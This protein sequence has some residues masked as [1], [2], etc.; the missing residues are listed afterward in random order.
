MP[1]RRR[2]ASS[3]ARAARVFQW[4][5]IWLPVP[6]ILLI[7]KYL[8]L[9]LLYIF[10]YVLFRE[11]FAQ[12]RPAR[13]AQHITVRDAA[14]SSQAAPVAPAPEPKSSPPA[15]PGLVVLRSS[16]PEALPVGAVVGLEPVLTIGRSEENSLRLT[17]HFVSSHH[18][19][20]HHADG[21]HRLR[22]ETSTNGTFVNGERV[23]SEIVLE[24]GD[25]VEIG[26]TTFEFREDARS[27]AS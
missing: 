24:D 18:A 8:F 6:L 20:I 27:G 21:R 17:D 16:G 2:G 3:L 1:L 14:A 22:D 5:V 12:L 19:V 25:Q 11:M 13:G 10:I 15:T 26:A 23:V 4:A 9:A 7:G